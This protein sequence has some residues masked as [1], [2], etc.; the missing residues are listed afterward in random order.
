MI[1]VSAKGFARK[2]DNFG[3]SRFDGAL[4]ATPYPS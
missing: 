1:R 4:H 2:Q 3:G